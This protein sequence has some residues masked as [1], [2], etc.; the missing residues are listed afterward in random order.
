VLVDGSVGGSEHCPVRPEA[1]QPE[2][3]G[4][5]AEPGELA[6]G[7]VARALLGVADGARERHAAGEAGER[8][9]VTD[10]FER[11]CCGSVTAS[12]ERAD[13]IEQTFGEHLIDTS[14]E[15]GVESVARRVKAEDQCAVALKRG[16]R[17]RGDGGPG[18][19][20]A[21]D[22]DGADEA[23]AIMGVDAAGGGRIET[24]EIAVEQAGAQVFALMEAR[25]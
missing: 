25:S 8:L 24:A 16:A 4:V 11:F 18:L 5:A 20:V 21:G 12:L 15:A 2:D 23:I 22:F 3:A 1:G 17:L 13:F 19:R 14:V 7:V 10:T 9:F 6:F